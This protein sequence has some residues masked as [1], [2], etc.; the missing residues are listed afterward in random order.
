[1]MS[2]QIEGSGI[3]RWLCAAVMLAAA[4]VCSEGAVIARDSFPDAE[5]AYGDGVSVYN[6]DPA[7]DT[8]YG[9]SGKWTSASSTS[10]FVGAAEGLEYPDI[11]AAESFPGAI[12]IKNTTAGHTTGRAISR[13]LAGFEASGQLYFSVLINAPETALKML[14]S[15]QAYGVG[16]GVTGKP[17]N[18]DSAVLPTEGVYVGYRKDESGSKGSVDGCGIILRADGV[19]TVI[20]SDPV[21]GETYFVVVQVTGGSGDAPGEVA[22]CVNPE[23]A[24]DLSMD[25]PKAAVLPYTGSMEWKYLTF[26]GLYATGGAEMRYDEVIL[27]DTLEDAVSFV[28]ENMPVF[29]D[30][31]VIRYDETAKEFVFSAGLSN[32]H[33]DLYALVGYEPGVYVYTNLVVSGISAGENAETAAEWLPADAVCC[34]AALVQNGEYS[35]ELEGEQPVYSGV[36]SAEAVSDGDEDGQKPGVIDVVRAGTAEAVS[37]EVVVEYT[38]SGTALPGINY[39]SL[40]GTITIPAGTNRASVSV[41]PMV[42]GANLDDVTVTLTV[43]GA[44]NAVDDSSSAT[45]T[46][47]SVDL[48]QGVNVWVASENGN[49]SD[50]KNWSLGRVP[51]STD[52]ILLDFYSVAGMR[53]DAGENG[54]PANVASWTQTAAYTNRV[55]IPTSCTGDFTAFVIDGDAVLDGGVWWRAGNGDSNTANVWLNIRAGGNLSVGKDFLFDGVSYG[56]PRRYGPAP[57]GDAGAG[58]G[59]AHGGMGGTADDGTYGRGPC[60]GVLKEPVSLGSGGAA[61]SVNGGGAVIIDA[62]GS[63]VF[64]G[65]IN[66]N[67]DTSASYAGPSAGSVLIKAESFTGAGEITAQGGFSTGNKRNGGGGGRIAIHVRGAGSTIDSFFDGFTGVISASGGDTKNESTPHY[68]GAAGTVYIETASDA[69]RGTLIVEN[70]GGVWT[71]T[72]GAIVANYKVRGDA[73]V[74]EPVWDV[75]SVRLAKAGRIGIPA[76]TE[77]CVPE[78]SAISGDGHTQNAIVLID[79][80]RLVSGVQYENLTLDG[81]NLEVRGTNTFDTTVR[82]KAPNMLIVEGEFSAGGLVLDGEY[83]PNGDY[84]ADSLG[85]LVGGA[86]IIRIVGSRQSTFILVK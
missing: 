73:Q 17:G 76:G 80:G 70:A 47:K 37:R 16:F 58:K 1:M 18:S 24:E 77:L 43:T 33:G 15:G 61:Y 83:I 36:I 35:V 22:A 7:H 23:T 19:N 52:D 34:Y 75:S 53:W 39:I 54:L 9:F 69:G 55:E 51:I 42:D 59:A 12:A 81:Y 13:P 2:R 74:T 50:P 68:P 49:A 63:I 4:Q 86:G 11:I 31:P 60:Y 84:S 3:E 20:L 27:A 41:R 65:K 62:A 44:Y 79:G 28:D 26:S 25:S 46:I 64:D 78:F 8:I 72:K 38:V 48:P 56:F 85:E 14:E 5:G 82:V 71:N 30:S 32:G 6:T 45:I 57:G 67:G 21:P 66:V 40:P 10:V 29:V